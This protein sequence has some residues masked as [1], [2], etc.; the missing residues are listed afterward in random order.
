MSSQKEENPDHVI[1]IDHLLP[2]QTLNIDINN[3]GEEPLKHYFKFLNQK[4]KDAL[5]GQFEDLMVKHVAKNYTLKE[6]EMMEK[7][8]R[9]SATADYE[10]AIDELEKNFFRIFYNEKENLVPKPILK[11]LAKRW[12]VD[13]KNE[14]CK[15]LRLFDT[16]KQFLIVELMVGKSN[17]KQ[18]PMNVMRYV[19]KGKGINFDQSTSH[20]ALFEAMKKLFSKGCSKATG[21]TGMTGYRL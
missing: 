14:L 18:F 9:A 13:E 8:V 6:Q 2:F 15:G 16:Q 5:T 11:G 20:D 4:E 19:A 21:A 3:L 7:N 1:D 12:C 17:K 10:L